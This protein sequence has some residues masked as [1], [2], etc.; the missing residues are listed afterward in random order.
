MTSLLLRDVCAVVEKNGKNV[1]NS[2]NRYTTAQSLYMSAENFPHYNNNN[3][4]STVKVW[5]LMW[6]CKFFFKMNHCDYFYEDIIF[7]TFMVLLFLLKKNIWTLCFLMNRLMQVIV[8]FLATRKN[9]V[10]LWC[11]GGDERSTRQSVLKLMKTPAN[12]SPWYGAWWE[13]LKPI[14]Q[15]SNVAAIC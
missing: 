15:D 7:K 11:Y 1:G 14:S 10:F 9:H 8:I 6:I 4:F 12:R 3:G 5:N 2:R 13:T